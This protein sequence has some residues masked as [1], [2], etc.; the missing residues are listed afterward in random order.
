MIVSVKRPQLI[1]LSHHSAA[2]IDATHP[3]SVSRGLSSPPF[4]T[5]RNELQNFDT[6]N[7]VPSIVAIVIEN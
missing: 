2:L 7:D 3:D 1:I 4:A 5:T 6:E